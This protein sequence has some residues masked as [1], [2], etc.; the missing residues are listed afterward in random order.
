LHLRGE[1]LE[2]R[3]S[4]I[5]QYMVYPLLAAA[6]VGVAAGVDNREIVRRLERISPTP[7]RLQPVQ[8][9]GGAYALR[10]DYKSTVETIYAALVTLEKIPAKRRIVV[11]GDID[12]P[13]PPERPHYRE[14]G[15]RVAAVADYVL[16]IGRKYDRY[17]PGLR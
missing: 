7:G 13:P 15:R 14:V 3:T 11:L 8:L 17:R 2:A 5:G 4:L 10:D 9:P 12:A 16:F 1:R 6:A